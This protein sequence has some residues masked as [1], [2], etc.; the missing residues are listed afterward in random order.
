MARITVPCCSATFEFYSKDHK[1]R[2]TEGSSIRQ[3]MPI[4]AKNAPIDLAMDRP[5]Q[6]IG[7]HLYAGVAVSKGIGQKGNEF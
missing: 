6:A 2:N 1:L 4:L 3:K 5:P 7:R